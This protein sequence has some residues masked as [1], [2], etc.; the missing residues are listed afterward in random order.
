MPS[1]EEDDFSWCCADSADSEILPATA[2]M[3]TMAPGA[4]TTAPG[5]GTGEAGGLGEEAARKRDY[6]TDG[7]AASANEE[8]AARECVH[9][10]E[11][12]RENSESATRLGKQVATCLSM[13]A[14]AFF[15]RAL[16]GTVVCSCSRLG[17]QPQRSRA[18]AWFSFV[19]SV[20]TVGV[21]MY[22]VA[23]TGTAIPILGRATEEIGQLCPPTSSSQ[24]LWNSWDRAELKFWVL[25]VLTVLAVFVDMLAR[26]IVSQR[27][28]AGYFLWKSEGSEADDGETYMGG[29]DGSTG[30]ESPGPGRQRRTGHRRGGTGGPYSPLGD[31]L[32]EP[33]GKAE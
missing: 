2:N 4:S 9:A 19:Y 21:L 33:T 11:H 24:S 3:T 10:Q 25:S 30:M 15:F 12:L 5:S 6:L 28:R 8:Y 26:E 17:R 14:T 18:L 13:Y 22:A 1:L 7:Q 27:H 23:T 16:L 32:E 31:G 29:D 20:F